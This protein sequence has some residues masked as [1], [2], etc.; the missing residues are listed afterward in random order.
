M[1]D[2]LER[3]RSALAD[4]YAVESEIGRGG[5]ATVF[6]AE[7][8]RHERK[9]AIKVLHPQLAATLGPQR[10]LSEIKIAAGLNHP[11]I[12]ALFDSGEAAGLLYYVMPYVEGESL[13]ERLEA[14]VQLPI[15]EAVAIAAEVA[16]GLDYAHRQGVIHRD[17]KP[18]NILL[19]EGHALIA[20]FGIARA[21]GA[22]SESEV[23]ATGLAVGTPNYMSPEQATADANVDGRS[24]IYALGCVLYEMLAGEPPFGGPTPQ[25]IMARK[26]VEE[27][28]N[29]RSVRGRIPEALEACLESA[30]APSPADRFATAAE[31]ASALRDAVL[32]GVTPQAVARRRR[33][34]RR[35]WLLAA[36]CMA[37]VAA[38]S[39]AWRTYAKRRQV[40]WARVEGIPEVRRLGLAGEFDSAIVVATRVESILPQDTELGVLW[41]LISTQRSIESIPPGAEV[42]RRAYGAA[43]EAPWRFVGITP[44]DSVRIPLK[45]VHWRFKKDGYVPRECATPPWWPPW[46]CHNLRAPADTIRGMVWVP[47]FDFESDSAVPESFSVG[48]YLLDRYETT[49]RQYK[50]FVDGGGYEKPE[51]W[52]ETFVVDGRVLRWDEAIALLIDS[53]GEP[54]PNTWADG[55]YPEGQGDYPVGGISWYEADAY[56]RFRGKSL[57]TL[58]HLDEAIGDHLDAAVISRSNIGE[59]AGPVAVGSLANPGTYMMYDQY[60]NVREWTSNERNSGRMSFGGCWSDLD[61]SARA[62]EWREIPAWDRS[63]ENGVRLAVYNDTTGIASAELP[64]VPEPAGASGRDYREETPATQSEFDAYAQL[65]QYKKVSLEST[66]GLRDTLLGGPM[67]RVSFTGPDGSEGMGAYIFFPRHGRPP[68]QTVIVMTGYASGLRAFVDEYSVMFDFFLEAGRAVVLP[69]LKGTYQAYDPA[70]RVS[71]DILQQ[72]PEIVVQWVKELR[73]TIDYLETQAEIDDTR[74][75]Y[76][77]MYFGAVHAPIILALEPRIKVGFAES[78]SL[79]E[80]DLAPEVDPL[81]F[82]PRVRTPLLVVNSRYSRQFSYEKGQVPMVELLGTPPEHKRLVSGPFHDPVMIFRYV[83]EVGPWFDKYLGPVAGF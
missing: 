11:H 27:A 53:S 70:T 44:T 47:G 55:T 19:S 9:V 8:L 17:I 20:D 39:L 13:Q 3:L 34:R 28:P 36:G 50:E 51:Y 23:V 71:D 29:V 1:P 14:E 45:Y 43:P 40:E 67:E 38:G 12:L 37:V 59:T 41:G 81:N 32:L 61:T 6:L 76:Y 15:D 60:G 83:S 56:A 48:D 42:F 64:L 68:F 69:I 78:G 30:V 35:R 5:M 10:F 18:G 16:E 82:L 22:A 52:Q 2:L 73:R 21:I 79:L 4:R 58:W 65:Y 62:W 80:F 77:G 33:H 66:V 72:P 63:P 26:A 49:N 46:P 7:D 57:P 24:D 31:F 25:V 54:G 75:A 74:I